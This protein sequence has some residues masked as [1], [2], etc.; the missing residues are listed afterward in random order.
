MATVIE[1]IKL[2]TVSEVAEAMGVTHQTVRKYIKTGKLKAQRVG[3]S[4]LITD[5]SIKAFLD[6]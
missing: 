6:V 4:L 2:F 5:K 3:K 1:G